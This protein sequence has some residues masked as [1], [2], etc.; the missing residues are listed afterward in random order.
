[1]TIYKKKILLKLEKKIYLELIKKLQIKYDELEDK[2]YGLS[3]DSIILPDFKKISEKNKFQHVKINISKLTETGEYEDKEIIDG[4]C[5]HNITWDRLG[6][7][8]QENPKLFLDKLYEFI[9][10]Y[11]IENEIVIE[12]NKFKLEYFKDFLILIDR[13]EEFTKQAHNN[14]QAELIKLDEKFTNRELN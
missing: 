8:K 4:V 11:V 2:V 6:G 3:K 12:N 10:Q 9:Q 14:F 13:K 1:M 5:Q 7:L